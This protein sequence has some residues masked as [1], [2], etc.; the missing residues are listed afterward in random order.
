MNNYIGK[1]C[2]YCKCAF[3]PGDNIVVCSDCDMP[4]HMDCW[5][6]NQGCTTFGCQGTLKNADGSATS[7]TQ[8]EMTMDVAPAV[9]NDVTYCPKC[10]APNS[11]DSS[12]CSKCGNRLKVEPT[13]TYAQAYTPPPSPGYGMGYGNNQSSYGGY[14]QGNGQGYSSSSGGYSQYYQNDVIAEITPLIGGNAE[15]YLPRFQNFVTQS[16]KASWNW[17][18]FLFTPFWF[19]YRRMYWHGIGIMVCGLLL[20]LINSVVTTGA[21][22]VIAIFANYIYME[23]LKKIAQQARTM[24]EPYKSQFMAK[25]TGASTT[26]AVL[27]AIGYIVVFSLLTL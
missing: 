19:I 10:G 9:Q 22:I 21:Y 17:A 27:A 3:E 18:A 5:V 4:H 7:V 26:A 25:H 15:Y 1:I 12:F 8:K 16:K 11:Q 14:T 6:E 23:H 24:T 20:A 2:P 13:S